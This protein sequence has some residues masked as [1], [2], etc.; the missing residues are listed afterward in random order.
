VIGDPLLAGASQRTVKSY[1]SDTPVIGENS[2]LISSN[3]TTF[4][5]AEGGPRGTTA[6][7]ATDEG[8]VSF[9][10]TAAMMNEY[11]LPLVR[12]KTVQLFPADLPTT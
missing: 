9:A 12:P 11:E 6:F 8:P 5:G 10:F 7:V 4:V 3:E 1:A 2:Q